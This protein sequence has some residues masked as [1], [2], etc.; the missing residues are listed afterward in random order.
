MCQ[1]DLEET[2]PKLTELF[3][4]QPKKCVLSLHSSSNGSGLPAASL[5]VT[6]EVS[7]TGLK[8]VGLGRARKQEGGPPQWVSGLSPCHPNVGLKE[9]DLEEWDMRW[10]W[11]NSTKALVSS[12]CIEIP[13][14]QPSLCYKDSKESWGNYLVQALKTKWPVCGGLYST[15]KLQ[16]PKYSHHLYHELLK[17]FTEV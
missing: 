8:P 11:Q 14:A 17:I 4:S 10:W 1:C 15:Q 2:G 13:K 12:L 5:S 9:P 16:T 7:L 3:E 6:D